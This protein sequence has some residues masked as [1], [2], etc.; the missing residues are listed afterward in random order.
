MS[1]KCV[2]SGLNDKNKFKKHKS[3]FPSLIFLASPHQWWRLL[4]HHFH[5]INGSRN[6]LFTSTTTKKRYKSLRRLIER[7]Q[8]KVLF[9]KK[10]LKLDKW[11][12]N[13]AIK[14]IT[15]T[16]LVLGPHGDVTWPVFDASRFHFSDDGGGKPA[17]YGNCVYAPHTAI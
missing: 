9:L 4:Y 15:N 13:D 11:R 2:H 17:R 6:L 14:V 7:D 12:M 3:V 8:N 16:L 5:I 1:L 10:Y